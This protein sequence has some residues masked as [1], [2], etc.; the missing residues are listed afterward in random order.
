MDTDSDNDNTDDK[1]E[2]DHG[3]NPLH[4]GDKDDDGD[5][6]PYDMENDLHLSDSDP[7]VMTTDSKMERSVALKGAIRDLIKAGKLG[8]EDEEALSEVANLLGKSAEGTE[9][10]LVDD[11]A[12]DIEEGASA[13]DVKDA[14]EDVKLDKEA[15][16]G[17]KEREE[18]FEES[19]QFYKDL[20]GELNDEKIKGVLGGEEG[21]EKYLEV[22]KASEKKILEKGGAIEDFRATIKDAI[23]AVK[24]GLV[25]KNTNKE[26]L[27]IIKSKGYDP[28]KVYMYAILKRDAVIENEEARKMLE[29]VW[30][31]I[32]NKRPLKKGFGRVVH[33]DS[34]TLNKIKGIL[35]DGSLS[36]EEKLEKIKNILKDLEYDGKKEF[37]RGKGDI[38]GKR[39]KG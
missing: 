33:M 29:D 13:K 3:R 8:S 10:E 19:E 31:E 35:A 2:M 16:E 39:Y 4:Y 24:N 7:I 32:L 34:E 37:G 1:D 25:E 9:K 38:Q 26:I 12:K 5:G 22:I 6:L 20:R 14:V 30:K 27:D 17:P 21:V 36:K 11:I 28:N 15:S 18:I 23:K